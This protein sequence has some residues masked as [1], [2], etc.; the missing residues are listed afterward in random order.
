M[1]KV[2]QGLEKNNPIEKVIEKG[3]QEYSPVQKTVLVE[4]KNPKNVTRVSQGVEK[5]SPKNVVKVSQGVKK[6]NT[7]QKMVPVKKENVVKKTTQVE[8]SL[9]H[10]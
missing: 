6:K 10:I 7:V 2:S 3:E 1:V 9:I 8:L 4:K 5:K